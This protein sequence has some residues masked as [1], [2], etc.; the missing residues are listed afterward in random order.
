MCSNADADIR[1]IMCVEVLPKVLDS[2]LWVNSLKVIYAIKPEVIEM[3][4][5]DKVAKYHSWICLDYGIN[6]WFLNCS[7]GSR[8]PVIV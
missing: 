6:L 7:E 2:L 4:V 3:Y 1:K 8:N 5:Y